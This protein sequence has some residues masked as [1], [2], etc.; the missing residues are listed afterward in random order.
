MLTLGCLL[1]D[2]VDILGRAHGQWC[3]WWVLDGGGGHGDP[4]AV[5]ERRREWYFGGLGPPSVEGW[6]LS[7]CADQRSGGWVV[8]RDPRLS[9]FSRVTVTLSQFG[10]PFPSTSDSTI[11]VLR[12]QPFFQQLLVA[13]WPL[14][15]LRSSS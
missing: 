8:S 6:V 2:L 14:T 7:K 12:P 11:L 5:S 13:L 4:P 3:R 9:K 1:V 15:E 10:S